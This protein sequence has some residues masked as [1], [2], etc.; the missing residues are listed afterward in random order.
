MSGTEDTST[1]P[2]EVPGATSVTDLGVANDGP[3]TENRPNENVEAEKPQ[4]DFKK[5]WKQNLDS[6]TFINN[7]FGGEL[8]GKV[9]DLRVEV[10]EKARI[11]ME[12]VNAGSG[13]NKADIK[14]RTENEANRSTQKDSCE[15]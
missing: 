8:L 6:L 3:S 5:L 9:M 14:V 4:V 12:Q 15:R 2:K 13:Y 1:R 11:Y 7:V 10:E